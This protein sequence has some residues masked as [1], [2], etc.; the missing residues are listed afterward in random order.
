[1]TTADLMPYIMVAGLTTNVIAV[2]GGTW[3]AVAVLLRL[4]DSLRE[5]SAKI[6]QKNPPEGLL[7][8]VEQIKQLAGRDHDTLTHVQAILGVD[9]RNADKESGGH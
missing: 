6:G 9:K 5:M 3:K 1:M 7:G 4:H 2:I 8:D